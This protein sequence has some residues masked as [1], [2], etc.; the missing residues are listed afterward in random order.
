MDRWARA[1]THTRFGSRHLCVCSSLHAVNIRHIHLLSLLFH[2]PPSLHLPLVYLSFLS[3]VSY[4]SAYRTGS[5]PPSL[6]RN[7]LLPHSAYS[8]T[9]KMEVTC[10]SKMIVMIYQITW[11]HSPEYRNLHSHHLFNGYKVRMT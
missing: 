7:Q 6:H 5:G 10:S 1:C 8:S 4:R 2:F 9:L 3:A 11:C